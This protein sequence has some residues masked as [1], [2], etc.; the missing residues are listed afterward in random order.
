MR[1]RSTRPIPDERGDGQGVIAMTNRVHLDGS[2]GSPARTSLASVPIESVGHIVSISPIAALRGEILVEGVPGDPLH[3]V[4]M[5]LDLMHTRACQRVRNSCQILR[6]MTIS[7]DLTRDLPSMTENTCAR[8]SVLPVMI[9]L[10][11]GLHA[12][13]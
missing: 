12:R 2:I 9:Y 10:P 7:H 13:S 8:L 5:V 6:S 11:S 1:P 4:R 3:K